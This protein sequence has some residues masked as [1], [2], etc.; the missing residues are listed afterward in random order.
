MTGWDAFDRLLS[1]DPV[2]AGCEAA[3]E[4]LH[5]YGELL[6][7]DALLAQTRYPD[8]AAHIRSCGPCAEDLEG[9]LLA[10]NATV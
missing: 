2:D 10:L 8:V 7:S 3:L 1:T 9:L 5:V 4:L 6:D